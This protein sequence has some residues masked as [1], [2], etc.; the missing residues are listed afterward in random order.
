MVYNKI[1]IPT[2]WFYLEYA[3]NNAGINEYQSKTSENMNEMCY[4]N[5]G[6]IG[7]KYSPVVFKKEN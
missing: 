6:I 4:I 7:I 1:S 5:V 2:N 3:R